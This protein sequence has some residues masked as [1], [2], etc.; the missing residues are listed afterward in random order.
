[1]DRYGPQ[2]QFRQGRSID[3]VTPGAKTN[4]LAR[5][6]SDGDH[7]RV[8]SQSTTSDRAQQVHPSPEHHHVP[9]DGHVG[10]DASAAAACRRRSRER[11][12]SPAWDDPTSPASARHACGQLAIGR[13]I[14]LAL[15]AAI[16]RQRSIPAQ[17]CTT[18]P[19]SPITGPLSLF[20]SRSG[21]SGK[22]IEQ[23]ATTRWHDPACLAQSRL[24]GVLGLANMFILVART[25]PLVRPD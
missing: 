11:P 4:S 7:V 5:L 9:Y 24:T 3:P 16:K 17:N 8:Q 12:L 15:V 10:E 25:V 1:M 6:K 22:F 21:A 19:R 18:P 2:P 13:G 20:F 23:Q 14:E